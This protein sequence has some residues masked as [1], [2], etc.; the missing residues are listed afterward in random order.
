MKSTPVFP[1]LLRI[2][3]VFGILEVHVATNQ[4]DALMY[5]RCSH[6]VISS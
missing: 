4:S 3:I 1:I 2:G 6:K 5:D